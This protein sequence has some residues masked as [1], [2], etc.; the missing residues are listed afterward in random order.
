MM[1]KKLK[2]PYN[3]AQFIRTCGK[4]KL[5]LVLKM[6]VKNFKNL[7]STATKRANCTIYIEEKNVDKD[8]FQ[9]ST[10]VWLQVRKDE[11]GILYYK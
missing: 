7:N 4:T 8:P 10:V 3:W 5:L 2:T 9:I 6:S 11:S 1:K